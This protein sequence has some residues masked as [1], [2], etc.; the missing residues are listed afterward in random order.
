MLLRKNA[1]NYIPV[2]EKSTFCICMCVFLI[3]EI[4]PLRHSLSSGQSKMAQTTQFCRKALL[5]K[6]F[7][8]LNMKNSTQL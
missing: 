1:D 6:I 5:M 7:T 8:V 4:D 3:H 2:P